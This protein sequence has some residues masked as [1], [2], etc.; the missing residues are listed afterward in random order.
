MPEQ[1]ERI[2][3]YAQS[4]CS[5]DDAA[6]IRALGTRRQRR[7]RTGQAVLGTGAVAL[8]GLGTTMT[9]NATSSPR[10]RASMTTAT[11][12][13]G[14]GL[15]SLPFISP[16]DMCAGVGHMVTVI[17]SPLS[18]NTNVWII[19][20]NSNSFY[21]NYPDPQNHCDGDTYRF[22]A[23]EQEVR[24]TLHLLGFSAV[25]TT[26]V[27]SATVPAGDVVDIRTQSGLSVLKRNVTPTTP[28]VVVVSRGPAT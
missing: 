17:K 7:R 19:S 1:F 28:L 26:T 14:N 24:Q 21:A 20:S 18:P 27:S 13:A 12:T 10:A 4:A 11:A 8:I 9:F 22:G 2:T 23:T 3:D 16:S 5:L 25:T 15:P 6:Q